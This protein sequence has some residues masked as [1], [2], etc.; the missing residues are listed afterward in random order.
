M[1]E[2]RTDLALEAA[3][4]VTAAAGLAGVEQTERTEDGVTVTVVELR[5]P[6]AAE[7]VGKPLGR[8]VTLELG[9]VQRREAEGFQRACHVLAG[10][11]AKL[12]SPRGRARCWWWGWATGPSRRTPS[13]P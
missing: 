6:E 1:P 11:L 13:G 4:A 3:Q 9:P 8:Y 2:R 7:K 5:T 12:Q 10:E